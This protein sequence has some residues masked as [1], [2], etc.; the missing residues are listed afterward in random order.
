MQIE[1]SAFTLFSICTEAL[2]IL[3][4]KSSAGVFQAL[5]AFASCASKPPIYMLIAH[6]EGR[7]EL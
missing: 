2:R 3:R 5:R 4:Y 7:W 6:W 1:A